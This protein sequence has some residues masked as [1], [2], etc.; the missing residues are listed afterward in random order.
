MLRRELGINLASVSG[1]G[2][3]LSSNRASDGVPQNFIDA[4]AQNGLPNGARWAILDAGT[5]HISAIRL[6]QSGWYLLDSLQRLPVKIDNLKEFLAKQAYAELLF[7]ASENDTKIV[8]D[9]IM[10]IIAAA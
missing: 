10:E 2:A 8:S 7:P 9:K 4:L 6:T 5:N 3:N 1:S